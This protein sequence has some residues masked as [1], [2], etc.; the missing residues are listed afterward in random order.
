MS[1]GSIKLHYIMNPNTHTVFHCDSSTHN[2]L[3]N[4]SFEIQYEPPRSVN[5][6]AV[7]HIRLSWLF[8]SPTPPST[9]AAIL[10]RRCLISR[11]ATPTA[12]HQPESMSR[13]QRISA[14]TARRYAASAL[15]RPDRPSLCTA[16]VS[17]KSLS[18][19]ST[20]IAGTAAADLSS[21]EL[22]API[23]GPTACPSHS[24]PI[25][26]PPLAI[27]SSNLSC[28]CPSRRCHCYPSPMS[29]AKTA[30]A[31]VAVCIVIL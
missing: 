18:N 12:R 14:A 31:P 4:E 24:E 10:A 23:N 22:L 13:P 27:I 25:P 19:S 3:Q 16:A 20:V 30:A 21:S 5:A 9:T 8:L 17:P 29:V 7:H 6:T 11:I 1:S 28:R 26:R 15:H 2:E